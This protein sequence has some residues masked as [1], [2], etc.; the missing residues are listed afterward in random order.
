M[1]KSESKMMSGGQTGAD[2]GAL[3]AAVA[4]TAE[5]LVKKFAELGKTCGTAESCTGGGVGSAITAVAGSSAVFWGGIISYDN[6]VKHGVLGVGQDV[7]D[8]V[9]PVSAECAEQ[10]AAGARKVLGV[11][12]AVSVTGLAG[13]GGDGVRPAGFVWF[14]VA[15][16]DGVKTENVVFPGGRAEVRAAAVDHALG[17]LLAAADF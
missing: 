7:L 4:R 2:L 17:M 8:G 14:G 12:Y 10:M 13:P 11:D 1:N 15:G 5:K 16:P 3:Q 6:S 9:G